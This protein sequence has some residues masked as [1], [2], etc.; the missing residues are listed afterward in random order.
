MGFANSVR[1]DAVSLP[2]HTDTYPLPMHSRIDDGFDFGLTLPLDVLSV[3][4]LHALCHHTVRSDAN[5]VNATRS[6]ET[7]LSVIGR[8][9]FFP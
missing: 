2:T 6:Y 4:V 7:N 5:Y 8:F 9:L 3:W 1:S